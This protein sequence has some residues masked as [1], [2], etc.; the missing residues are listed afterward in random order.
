M[1]LPSTYEPLSCLYEGGA[2]VLYECKDTKTNE[3]VV[4]KM[5]PFDK[6]RLKLYYENEIDIL[7][8]LR[9]CPN[10]IKMK[11]YETYEEHGCIFLPKMKCDLFQLLEENGKFEENT[12]KNIFHQICSA[13]KMCHDNGIAHLDIKPENILQ[14]YSGDYYLADFGGSRR[15]KNVQVSDKF[16]MVTKAYCAPE[17]R[18]LPGSVSFDPFAADVWSLG[19][20]LYTLLT[21][22][23]PYNQALNT[24]T[25][26][27]NVEL[28]HP[29]LPP[30]AE[31]FLKFIL[32][33]DFLNR[34]T[35]E[36]IIAHPWFIKEELNA[37]EQRRYLRGTTRVKRTLNSL[38]SKIRILRNRI[39]LSN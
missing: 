9:F 33:H 2:S 11:E 21:G 22:T 6:P 32:Q 31:N 3:R 8:D 23:W 20:L 35:I 27:T 5:I 13:V 29:S 39:K 24:L 15:L 34:P 10:V 38:S 18:K 26:E 37:R 12:T 36:Q 28:A 4:A 16:L 14:S 25:P 19:V 1:F 17:L 30:P 7:F